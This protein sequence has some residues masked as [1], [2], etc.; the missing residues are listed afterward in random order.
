[1][2]GNQ[3]AD[4]KLSLSWGCFLE[5]SWDLKSEGGNPSKETIFRNGD[6]GQQV[7]WRWEELQ[8]GKLRPKLTGL[9][10]K[11]ISPF[12]Q[13]YQA[14]S[15]MLE[16]LSWGCGPRQG[17]KANMVSVLTDLCSL[18]ALGLGPSPMPM[19]FPMHD[20]AS[21]KN[22]SVSHYCWLQWHSP[23]MRCQVPRAEPALQGDK[24]LPSW[25]R[26]GFSLLWVHEARHVFSKSLSFFTCQVAAVYFPPTK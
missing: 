4:R 23:R 1:M 12:L 14:G 25:V 17:S 20:L 2:I 11:Q 19:L 8:E 10:Y 26:P 9:A 16:A 5:V 21:Q 15:W 24:E 6:G 18:V 22:R 13:K 3:F 7:H